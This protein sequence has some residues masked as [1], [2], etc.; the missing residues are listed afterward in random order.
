[1]KQGF[2]MFLLVFL[3]SARLHITFT[4]LLFQNFTL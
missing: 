3:T 4:S 1:M 2:Q